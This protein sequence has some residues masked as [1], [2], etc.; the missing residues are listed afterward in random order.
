MTETIPA[1]RSITVYEED[2][3]LKVKGLKGIL[4]PSEDLIRLV[5]RGR[6]TAT[7]PGEAALYLGVGDGRH[8]EYLM[9]LGYHVIGTDVAPSSLEVTQKLFKGNDRFRG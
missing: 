3:R 9:S 5:V 8:V 7:E 2:F 6:I 1:S 4:H